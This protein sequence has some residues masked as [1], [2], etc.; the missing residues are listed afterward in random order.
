MVGYIVI[1][2][3]NSKTNQIK[4]KYSAEMMM[5]VVVSDY[6]IGQNQQTPPVAT[7]EPSL[8]NQF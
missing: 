4:K 3:K 1:L 2:E 8:S 7:F 6:Q 5:V